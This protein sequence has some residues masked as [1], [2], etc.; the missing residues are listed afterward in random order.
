MFAEVRHLTPPAMRT[1]R[2]GGVIASGPVRL[3]VRLAV[4]LAICAVG[5]VLGA[6]P[7]LA[8]PAPAASSVYARRSA[9]VPRPP[10]PAV[11]GAAAVGPAAPAAGQ[12]GAGQGDAAGEGSG[13][14]DAAARAAQAERIVAGSLAAVARSPALSVRLR[15]KARI[16]PRVLVGTGRYLQTGQ[17]EEQ[18]FRFESTL[19][20]DSE[21]FE[22]LEIC[23]GLFAWTYRR[24]GPHDPTLQR[25]DVRRVHDR[26]AELGSPAPDDTA[27][28]LGGLQRVLWLT[29]HW[30]RFTA[31]ESQDLD[32]VPTWI[33]DGEWWPGGLAVTGP[34]LQKLVK[35][36]AVIGPADLP[37]GVP[38]SVKLAIGRGDLMPRRIEWLAI[39]GERPVSPDAPLE[40]IAVLELFDV[41][42]D[43]RIDPASFYYQPAATGLMDLTDQHVKTLTLFRP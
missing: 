31:A 27:G 6:S 28:Y 22:L 4:C 2:W 34:P 18:K 20:S 39:P 15:Q 30:M 36:G 9:A 23:D 1:G 37:D 25:V 11:T 10:E 16:G 35:D 43:G 19:E 21:S 41:E 42:I 40:P 32:G 3:V 17:G 12:G 7:V 13:E 24:D 14:V 29:R 8:D 33:I 26:L 38:W 5:G